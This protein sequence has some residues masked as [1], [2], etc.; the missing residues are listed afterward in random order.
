M[1]VEK[2]KSPLISPK[3]GFVLKER[4]VGVFSESSGRLID[5][6]GFNIERKQTVLERGGSG[7]VGMS[8]E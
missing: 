2:L 7:R 3:R 5:S 6:C 8:G 4:K 1:S